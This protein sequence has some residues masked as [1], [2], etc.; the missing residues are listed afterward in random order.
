[1]S[2]RTQ[3]SAYVST[4]TK[5]MVERY[6]KAHGVKKGFL[7]ESALLHHMQALRELP[8]DVVIPP[9]ITVTR[10]SGEAMVERIERPREP[11]EA[12]RTLF[13]GAPDDGAD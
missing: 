3:I 10:E 11:T 5:E 12:M 8:A 9:V 1:M 4:E 7:I 6:A 13:E 2:S